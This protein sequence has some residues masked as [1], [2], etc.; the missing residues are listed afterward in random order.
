MGDD[1]MCAACLI[2]ALE[3]YR[4]DAETTKHSCAAIWALAVRSPERKARLREVGAASRA[5]TRKRLT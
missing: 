3:A 1:P 4:R 5:L 2:G